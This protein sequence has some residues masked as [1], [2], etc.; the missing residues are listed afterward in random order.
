LS[1]TTT[2]PLRA[3]A[4]PSCRGSPPA[5]AWNPPPWIHTMTGRRS[6][7]PFAG[8]QRFTLRQS[9]L[10][11]PGNVMSGKIG[12]CMHCGPYCAASRT[13]IHGAAGRGSFQRNSPAVV[14]A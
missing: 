4:S 9:S 13:A 5:P 6:L 7:A 14:A 2:T 11:G 8:V 1:V 12:P 3:S 10:G